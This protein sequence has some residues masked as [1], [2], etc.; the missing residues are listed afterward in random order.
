M[1]AHIAKGTPKGRVTAPPSKSMAHRL[2]ICAGL[3]QGKSRVHG[4]DMSQDVLATIDCLKA[5]GAD[6]QVE[7]GTVTV[8]GV[9]ALTAK[10]AS[11]LCCRESGSTLRF[12]IPVALL[13]GHPVQFTGSPYLLSRPL[14]V[15]KE[16]C[17]ENDLI[18]EQNAQGVLVQGPLPWGCIR[19]RGDVSSQFISG[20]LFALPLIKGTGS[21]LHLLP[22]IESRSYI[23][24]TRAAME[25][26]G[27]RTF[28]EDD[29]TLVIPGDQSYQSQDVTVEGD[30]SNAAFF[31][32]MNALG[33]EIEINGLDEN[34]LQGDRVYVQHLAALKK[35]YAAID[36]GDCP[37]LGPVLFAA[38]A[39][40]HGAHF[41]GTRRLRIKE[42]DRANAMAEE[43]QKFGA[44]LTVNENDVTV[45][46]GGL[47][48]PEIMLCGHNDHRIVM[49]LSVLCTLFGGSITDAQ[50]VNKSYPGFF[51]ALEK[52]QIQVRRED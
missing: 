27:V 25:T 26:F 12:F 18:F 32:A 17:A 11:P 28:W 44:R 5:L 50:A 37:D 1:I 34:S 38:S 49:A 42:S 13:S 30:Y 36:L 21:R 10:P 7:G 35:G 45:Y 47:H 51:D 31:A 14:S 4:V 29:L 24:L 6:V 8:T 41:T 3:S 16:L 43:L 9:D 46:P 23:E 39:A 33:G 20:L 19:V 52:L 2:L 40:L 22:P 48:A 15:Y